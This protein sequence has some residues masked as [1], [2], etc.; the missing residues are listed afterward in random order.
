MPRTAVYMEDMSKEFDNHSDPITLED[1]ATFSEAPVTFKGRRNAPF[2]LNSLLR[3]FDGQ[4]QQR[5]PLT[6][7]PVEVNDLEPVLTRD[8]HAAYRN[9]LVKLAEKGWIDG[10]QLEADAAVYDRRRRKDRNAMAHNGQALTD[11][12]LERLG[13]VEQATLWGRFC[14][15]RRGNGGTDAAR[16]ALDVELCEPLMR[17]QAESLPFCTARH[18]VITFLKQRFEAWSEC[19]NHTPIWFSVNSLCNDFMALYGTVFPNVPL[20]IGR[21]RIVSIMIEKA[22]FNRECHIVN[23]PN[24]AIAIVMHMWQR[25]LLTYLLGDAKEEE[26]AFFHAPH[27]DEEI[28]LRLFQMERRR[29]TAGLF[30]LELTDIQL[31]DWVQH[32]GAFAQNEEGYFFLRPGTVIPPISTIPRTAPYE[33]NATLT[34]L[35]R[36]LEKIELER[37]YQAEAA[38]ARLRP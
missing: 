11:F 1:L 28:V 3:F 25:H 37:R 9:T 20:Q 6:N 10:R 8:N 7:E 34:T 21:A 23:Y 18:H 29:H 32:S 36:G 16:L 4:A 30:V 38:A 27:T 5:D 12:V 19:V 15:R 24:D 17:E 26:E 31:E 33:T 2:E 14:S 22:N 13:P 35:R